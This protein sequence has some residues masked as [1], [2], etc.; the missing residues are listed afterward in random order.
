MTTTSVHIDYADAE[1]LAKNLEENLQ[2]DGDDDREYWEPILNRLKIAI[3]K[4]ELCRYPNASTSWLHPTLAPVVLRRNAPVSSSVW[5]IVHLYLSCSPRRTGPSASSRSIPV[6][7]ASSKAQASRPKIP[8]SSVCL[9]CTRT[10]GAA[11]TVAASS[12]CKSKEFWFTN[13]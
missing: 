7:T 13:D 4:P 9:M 12:P 10:N 5:P 11:L 2:Y 6:T 8:T 1:A 3:H